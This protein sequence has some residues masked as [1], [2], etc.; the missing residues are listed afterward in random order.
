MNK[1]LIR[2]TA[3]IALTIFACVPSF[4]QDFP[5]LPGVKTMAERTIPP[6]VGVSPEL[7]AIIASHQIPPYVPSP[8][9]QEEW[10]ELQEKFDAPFAEEARAAAK[11]LGVTYETKNIAGVPCYLVTPKEIS[12]RFKD[13]WLVHIH[14]GAFVFG[15]GDS[16][17]REALWVAD[18]LNAR[19][20]SIDYRCPPLHPF[21]AA[22]EDAVAVW[23]EVIKKQDAAATAL[24]GSSAGGNLTLAT[25][26]KLKQLG[27]PLPGALFAGTPA[28]DLGKTTDSWFTLQGLDPL[29]QRGGLIEG[30]FNVYVPSGDSSNPLVSPVYGDLKGFPP[31]ILISGT[32]DL[33]LSDT[34]RMHRALRIVDVNAELH[35]YDGQSHG[36]YMRGLLE[37]FPESQDAIKEIFRFF[38]K[39]L[40]R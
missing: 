34:V 22:I 29:G 40:K 21:P 37:P 10:L 30:T 4:A 2:L 1:I 8:T 11:R 6:P 14:G 26:L 16:A 39:H 12:E 27:L 31:T 19:V 28:T 38:D 35:I 9:T 13:R 5:P 15:G 23:K 18:G 17:L 33:L 7:S 3:F 20:I 24:F 36:D 25:T 32:R